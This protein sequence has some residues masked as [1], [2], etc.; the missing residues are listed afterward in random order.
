MATVSAVAGTA[1]IVDEDGV[2]GV[3]RVDVEEHFFDALVA[4]CRG[5]E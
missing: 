3:R 5:H 4:G 2:G 1:L